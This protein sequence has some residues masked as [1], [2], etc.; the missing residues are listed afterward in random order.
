VSNAFGSDILIQTADPKEAARFYVE[1]LGFAVDAETDELISLHGPNINL[2]IERGP[3]LGPIL[4]IMVDDVAAARGAL[5][6]AGCEII[7][8]EP[9]F[10]RTYVRDR[11]GLIYNLRRR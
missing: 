10:P 3:L 8:D 5:E 11:F 6:D 2:F 1:T 4:E 7:K 9:D